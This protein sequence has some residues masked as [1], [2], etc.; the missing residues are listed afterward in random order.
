MGTNV[1]SYLVCFSKDISFVLLAQLLTPHVVSLELV[2]HDAHA[3]STDF[4]VTHHTMKL[5]ETVEDRKKNRCV[6]AAVERDQERGTAA[7]GR[8]VCVIVDE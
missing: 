1:H 2:L 7:G 5:G 6:E 4:I 8:C 3:Q